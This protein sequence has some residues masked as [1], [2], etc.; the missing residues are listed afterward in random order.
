MADV[1]RYAAQVGA[2]PTMSCTAGGGIFVLASLSDLSP[3]DLTVQLDGASVVVTES[4]DSACA[5]SS[6]G[7]QLMAE[8]SKDGSFSL[9][10]QG[11]NSPIATCP[12]Q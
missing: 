8:R 10:I 1:E 3:E 4:S 12:R 5:L 2:S 6:H 9:L 7:W 11:Q